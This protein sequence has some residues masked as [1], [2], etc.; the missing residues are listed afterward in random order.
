M[1]S[2]VSPVVV[3]DKQEYIV[4]CVDDIGTRF[5]LKEAERAAQDAAATHGKTMQIFRLVGTYR[6]QVQ[7]SK[8]N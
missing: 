1:T 7:V 6:A 2:P 8:E 3:M 4:F 5:S